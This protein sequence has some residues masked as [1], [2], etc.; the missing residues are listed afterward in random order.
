MRSATVALII[1]EARGI[2]RLIETLSDEKEI[3]VFEHAYAQGEAD[4]LRAVYDYRT[5]Q[6]REEDQFSEY[7]E[8]LLARPFLRR[9]IQDHGIQWMRS[10]MKIEEYQRSEAE[11]A[12]II[13]EYAMNIVEKDPAQHDFLLAGPAAHVRIRVF[14]LNRQPMLQSA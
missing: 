4:P 5:R 13:A 2:P 9:E 12:K 7:V 14:L 6:L 11:A 1:R 10:K 3:E 8:D